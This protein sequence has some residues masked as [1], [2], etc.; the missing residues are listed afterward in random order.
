[1]SHAES[2]QMELIQGKCEDIYYPNPET[3]KKQC[4]PTKQTTKYVQGFNTLGAGTN[5]FL[6]PANFGI[7]GI[8]LTLNLQQ[9]AAGGGAGLALPR[10]WGY[11]LNK[12]GAVVA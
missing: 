12:M 4:I 1:M 9:V 5:T 8:C 7:Q 10:G 3:T 6:I 2:V 11:A